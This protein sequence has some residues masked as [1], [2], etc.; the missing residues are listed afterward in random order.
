MTGLVRHPAQVEVAEHRRGS[1][2]REERSR[3]LP[4]W[5]WRRIWRLG[6]PGAR[7]QYRRADLTREART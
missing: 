6:L 7:E 2:A 1:V 3:V 5:V 4:G